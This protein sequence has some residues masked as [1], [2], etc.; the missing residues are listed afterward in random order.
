MTHDPRLLRIGAADFRTIVPA[1]APSGARDRAA[2]FATD[3][4]RSRDEVMP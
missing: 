2:A 4:L 3:L 1:P